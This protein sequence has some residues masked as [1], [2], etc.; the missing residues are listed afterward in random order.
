MTLSIFLYVY[1]SS[2]CV[3]EEVLDLFGGCDKWLYKFWILTPFLYY[4]QIF[5]SIQWV[6]FIFLLCKT[7]LVWCVSI[8]LFYIFCF[9]CLRK[10]ISKNI[11]EGSVW[12]FTSCFLLGVKYL[13]HFG[14]ILLYGVKMSLSFSLILGSVTSLTLS[15]FLRLAGVF[16]VYHGSI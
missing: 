4:W 2:V 7:F 12:D 8:C 10:Y 16:G 13:T 6:V 9:S 14:F 11:T 5:S 3:F 15:I 1:W